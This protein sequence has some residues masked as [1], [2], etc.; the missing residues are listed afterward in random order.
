[1]SLVGPKAIRARALK[2]W[3]TQ[4]LLRAW[5]ADEP[6]FPFE[7]P[8]GTP[9][10]AQLAERFVEVRDWIKALKAEAGGGY[11]L[12]EQAV[13]HRQLGSQ[14]VPVR[15]VIETQEDAL[16]LAG[17]LQA[18]R[19]FEALVAETRRRL[20]ALM[21]YVAHRPLVVLDLADA[22]PGLLAVC[23]HL[24]AHPRPGGYLRALE[25]PGV[26]TKFVERHATVLWELLP[27]VLPPSAVDVAV[28]RRDA[29]AFE[30]RFGFAYDP[31]VVRFRALDPA[32]AVAGFDDLAVPLAAFA[33]WGG[34]G[35][36]TVVVTENKVNGLAFP[37][38]QDAIVLFGLGYGVQ[39]LG[40]VPWLAD[41][42]L[43][44]WGDL[45]THGF[46]I[47]AQLRERWPHTESFLM[48][49][50]TLLAHRAAWAQEPEA[51]RC[52]RDL[53]AL[54]AAERAVFEGLRADAWG[55]RVRLEQER[56]PFGGVERAVAGLG[57]M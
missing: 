10:G 51:Q 39:A 26:D 30:R 6:L 43:V 50:A 44:Y 20:P 2:L 12:V 9:S 1:M 19:R 28:A 35:V 5:L 7:V 17:K 45:D 18:F 54:T 42:R 4:R 49:E 3:D 41:R 56:I 32:L 8:L 27:L 52:L 13:A 14:L 38:L 11:R 53:A 57:G 25:T 48:D 16:R 24:A 40:E 37:A 21:E 47:L 33:A 29:H 23:E 36:R 34:P 55:P 15:A 31:P 22:W 46:G